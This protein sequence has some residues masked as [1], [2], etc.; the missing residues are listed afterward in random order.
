MNKIMKI[1][2]FS[3][4]TIVQILKMIAYSNTLIE[5]QRYISFHQLHNVVLR[6]RKVYQDLIRCDMM[7][8]KIF[9]ISTIIVEENQK[10][11]NFANDDENENA[12]NNL[13]LFVDE[14]NHNH[15]TKILQIVVDFD[16]DFDFSSFSFSQF[17]VASQRKKKKKRDR[18]FKTNK[19]ENFLNLLNVHFDFHF[20]DNVR[21]FKTI[22]NFNVLIEK[23]KHM[24][25][26]FFSHSLSN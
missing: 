22:I 4:K 19:F 25:N 10:I 12:K 5:N 9:F 15:M 17:T 13:I 8:K 2:I 24:S 20:V 6:I 26:V 1:E 7:S 18:K 16:F 21:E 11:D 23:F 3:L 14:T